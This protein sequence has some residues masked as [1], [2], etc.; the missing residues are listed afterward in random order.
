MIVTIHQ[1][2]HLVWLGLLS[3]IMKSDVFVVFDNTQFKKNYYENRNK[4]KTA[5]GWSWITVP[6]KNHP[7][8]TNI[9]MV[10][11]S[12][13]RK[14]QRKYLLTLTNCYSKTPYYDRYFGKIESIILKN[15]KYLIDLNMEILNFLLFEFGIN[16][17][18]IK[19]SELDVEKG[20]VGGSALC[21]SICKAT[22]ADVY[23]AGPSSRDYL[24][25]AEFEKSRIKV[26]FHEFEH[27]VYKQQFGNFEFFMSSLDALFN[28]GQDA[29]LLLK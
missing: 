21:L 6:V 19:S 18:I 5:T 2:E 17:R 22:G 24:D 27:P 14:W 1:P 9:N 8:K 28:L 10:E 29:K 13:D 23:L 4:I 12:Y 26:I 15:H 11:I 3:K 25:L 20:G 7:L 16:K